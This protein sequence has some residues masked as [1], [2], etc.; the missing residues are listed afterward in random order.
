MYIG[1]LQ[2]FSN[3]E[4][5]EVEIQLTDE[6]GEV[7]DF[8]DCDLVVSVRDKNGSQ[9]LAGESDDEITIPE[10]GTL[11]IRF[12]ASRVRSLLAGTYQVGLTVTDGTNTAQLLVCTVQ[13]IDG[14]VP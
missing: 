9:V 7:I 11:L 13:C 2:S 14:I 4:D 12:A 10:T 8:D 3:R 5:W 6:T 1:S